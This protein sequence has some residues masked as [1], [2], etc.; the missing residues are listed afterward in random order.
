[1][2]TRRNGIAL[3]ITLLFSGILVMM[4]SVTL[5]GVH[6]GSIFSQDYHGKTSAFYAAES[7]LAFLQSRLEENADYADNTVN[8]PTTFGTGTFTIKFGPNNCINNL[9]GTEPVDGPRGPVMPGSVYVRIEGHAQAH[10]EVIECVLGRSE[11]EL[12]AAAVVASGKIHLDG[13]VKITGRLSSDENTAVPADVISN[14]AEDNWSGNPPLYYDQGFGETALISG[15]IRSASPNPNA[16]SL[17]L[18]NAAGEA[19]T[20]Q[21]PVPVDNVDIEGQ[22][23]AKAGNPAPPITTGTLTGDYY[24]SGNHTMT[25]DLVLDNGR[26]YID[27]NLTVIGSI[28]GNGAVYVSGNTTFSGDSSITAAEDGV[29]L[30]SQGNISLRG[31]DGSQYMDAITAAGS[32]TDVLNWEHTKKNFELLNTYMTNPENPANFSVGTQ[33][34]DYFWASRVGIVTGYLANRIINSAAD[35]PYYM[36]NGRDNLLYEMLQVIDRQP[37]SPAKRFMAKKFGI[38]RSG[39]RSSYP[40]GVNLPGALGITY[41][42]TEDVEVQKVLDFLR[43]GEVSDG[44]FHFLAWLKTSRVEGDPNQYQ[45]LSDAQIDR[46]IVKMGAWL[47]NYDYDQL[48]SSYFKGRLYTRGALYAANEVTIVGSVA[49]VADPNRADSRPDFQPAA[50]VNLRP[51]DLYLA[52]G[53]TVTFVEDLRPGYNPAETS[54]GVRHWLR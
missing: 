44:L 22:I 38:L 14:Y 50:G 6:G 30:Y 31:F 11:D 26:V 43:T 13:D 36:A 29:V 47:N 46:A 34:P 32:S 18:V 39:D 54:V 27:G 53:T 25:G 41:S 8:E 7:G 9:T 51:G 19:L 48:G 45:A 1:M 3:I 5:I 37:D 49:A 40:S 2:N 16:I 4:L 10:R 15:T 24:K 23:A 21:A 35:H 20:N 17:D 52:S 42:S 12:V 33:D 28:K